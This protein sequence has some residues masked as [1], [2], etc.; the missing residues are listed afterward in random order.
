MNSNSSRIDSV[1][2]VAFVGYNTAGC[3]TAL[4]IGLRRRGVSTRIYGQKDHP[5]RYGNRVHPYP[6]L[7]PK[8]L[9]ACSR[10]LARMHRVTSMR[11]PAT[12]RHLFVLS[13]YYAR[14]AA[15]AIFSRYLGRNFDLVMMEEG[16]GL[17]FAARNL[18][19]LR[20]LGC[21]VVFIGF[22]SDVRPA[23]LNGAKHRDI[24]PA[25]TDPLLDGVLSQRDRTRFLEQ[26][27]VTSISFPGGAH[28]SA[29]PFIDREQLGFPIVPI[30]AI[31]AQP[32]TNTIRIAHAP[33]NPRAKGSDIVRSTVESLMCIDSRIEFDLVTGLSRGETMERLAQAD[34]VID[35]L[36]SDQYAGVLA[37][38]ALLL[39][40]PVIVGSHDA[41]WLLQYYGERIPEG[42]FL[43]LPEN[44]PS[45]LISLLE[46]LPDIRAVRA[47]RA[48]RFAI[49]D[50]LDVVTDRWLRAAMGESDP[51]WEFDPQAL[52][53]PLGGFAGLNELA[54]LIRNFV[55]RHGE[56]SLLVDDKP[57]LRSA[58]LARATRGHSG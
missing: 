33:S 20:R 45:T 23:Y 11:L 52:T 10:I 22:G 55:V 36:Y 16:T 5:F 15:N 1:R 19:G 57:A 38:E 46:N 12:L 35:Q 18:H 39:G 13:E 29:R 49:S 41:E 26:Q 8:L 17:A 42:I 27:G 4:E 9:Y 53:V 47:D 24:S 54:E 28:F 32:T 21:T 34:I 51:A 48:R 25:D 31:P 56:S 6:F 2:R 37:R 40:T 58:I 44:L 7:L 14:T 43:I 3:W 30:D 50:G